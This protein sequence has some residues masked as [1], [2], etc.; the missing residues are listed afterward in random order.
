MVE[1]E[2]AHG[3]SGLPPTLRQDWPVPWQPVWGP[4]DGLGSRVTG[5]L[6][7]GALGCA[8]RLPQGVVSLLVGALARIAK[9]VDRRHSE[10]ARGFQ[11]QALGDMPRAEMEGRVLQAYRHFLRVSIDMARFERCVPPENTLEHFD[12]EWSEDA[13]K[14]CE[15]EGGCILLSCHQGSWEAAFSAVRWMGFDP[16]YGVAKPPQN[17]LLSVALQRQREARGVRVLARRGARRDAKKV[18]EAGGVVGMVL[19]QRARKRPL[20]APFF[21][22]PARCDRSAAVLLKRLRVPVVILAC[23]V[24]ERPLYYSLV[25]DQV[26]WPDELAEASLEGIVTRINQ[27]FERLILAHPEQYFWL[28]DRFKDTPETFEDDKED[29]KEGAT[30]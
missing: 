16:A 23:Y 22:R 10:S 26:L 25:F 14:V 21:G 4:Q 11:R 18:I 27:S 24:T 9:F 28:H 15:S 13:R 29:V 17:R 1:R 12:I 2:E 6:A 30:A 20:I 5:A 7:L 19:D 3:P 8:A